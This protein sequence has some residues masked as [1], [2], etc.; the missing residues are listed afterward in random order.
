MIDSSLAQSL[1][2][3]EGKIHAL[4]QFNKVS[5][6][7]VTAMSYVDPATLNN[8]FFDYIEVT[9]FDLEYD[10]VVGTRDS[11]TIVDRRTL[12]EQV[13]ESAIDAIAR[14]K[15]TKEYPV[16]QQVNIIGR[17]IIALSDA[18]GV[19]QDELTEMLA[20]INEVKRV[21][22][23][24]KS[25]YQESPAYEFITLEEEEAAETDRLEGGINE[26]YGARPATG[27]RVF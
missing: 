10:V 7:F 1:A 17:A 5:G 8:D 11:Y 9:E 22:S 25:F 16:V 2:L 12:P 15:I 27:G 6:A 21:N 18:L 24:A 3:P 14:D 26:A 13:Y 19:P 23:L 20:Y 4:L